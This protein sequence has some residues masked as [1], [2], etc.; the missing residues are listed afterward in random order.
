MSAE[1][2]ATPSESAVRQQ[3]REHPGPRA[4]SA[5]AAGREPAEAPDPERAP[6]ESGDDDGFVAAPAGPDDDEARPGDVETDPAEPGAGGEG[7][8]EAAEVAAS[9]PLADA[10]R[11]RDEYL[12]LAQRT[13][14]DFDN[15]RRRAARDVAAA[16]PRAKAGLVRELLPA[17]DNLER[18][19][20]AAGEADQGLA[21]G[22]RMVHAELIGALERSGVAAYEPDGER[23]DPNVHEALS[24]RPADGAEPGMVVDVL[25][26]GYRLDDTVLRPAR[27]VV[28]A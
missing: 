3:M 15:F 18:A 12:V 8:D 28:S 7:D 10:E 2:R 26:K 25:E 6:D 4:A 14:A 22:V 27:V 11:Q 5:P 20:A 9:D 23:F 21:G 17:L 19:L 24:T 1:E 13:Q 16:G